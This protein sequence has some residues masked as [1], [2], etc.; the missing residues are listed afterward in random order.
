MASA[1]SVAT[2]QAE[3][4]LSR[5]PH[6][7]STREHIL[8]GFHGRAIAQSLLGYGCIVCGSGDFAGAF[9]IR[10]QIWLFLM[11]RLI[12]LVLTRLFVFCSIASTTFLTSLGES[13]RYA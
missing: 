5:S 1:S 8:P 11:R 4:A 2:R 6:H 13:S 12:V 3:R 9:L 10:F 7:H